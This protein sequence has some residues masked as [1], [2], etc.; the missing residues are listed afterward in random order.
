[1]RTHRV[2]LTIPHTPLG[3]ADRRGTGFERGVHVV[4]ASGE[5]HG[6][7]ADEGEPAFKILEFRAGVAEGEPL[8]PERGGG[9]PTFNLIV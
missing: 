3:S 6:Q 1:M 5:A 8:A 2:K 9:L 7:S 4:R